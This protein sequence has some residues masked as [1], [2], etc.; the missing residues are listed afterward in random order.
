MRRR[1][2]KAAAVTELCVEAADV[3]H[4]LQD[5]IYRKNYRG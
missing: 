1:S 4:G 3:D 5:K 2:R